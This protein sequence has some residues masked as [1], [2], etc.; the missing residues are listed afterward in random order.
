ML[1][2]TYAT[3]AKPELSK[4]AVSMSWGVINQAYLRPLNV[5]GYC[6]EAMLYM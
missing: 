6:P 4:L 3:L 2:L 1:L 5:A